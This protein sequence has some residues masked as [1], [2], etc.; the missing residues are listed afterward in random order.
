MFSLGQGWRAKTA[1]YFRRN[2]RVRGDFEQQRRPRELSSSQIII[3]YNYYTVYY[4]ERILEE[5]EVKE[6]TEAAEAVTTPYFGRLT[7]QYINLF[8]IITYYDSY[9]TNYYRGR[10]REQ[11]A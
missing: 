3:Y 11:N 4:S 10:K 2:S 8:I 9:C 7:Q 6:N 5:C 1:A